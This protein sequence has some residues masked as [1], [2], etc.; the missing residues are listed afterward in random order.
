MKFLKGYKY[1]KTLDI[2]GLLNLAYNNN[3]C[4]FGKL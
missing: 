2:Y 3:V 1:F 4:V